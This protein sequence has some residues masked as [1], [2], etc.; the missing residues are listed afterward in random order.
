VDSPAS[1]PLRTGKQENTR[2]SP[3]KADPPWA[4]KQHNN[5]TINP[6]NLFFAFLLFR[7][8][9]IRLGWICFFE[10]NPKLQS[11]HTTTAL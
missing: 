2:I 7:P 5:K 8:R 1:A 3:P 11:N 6:N 4:E 9:L 10:N